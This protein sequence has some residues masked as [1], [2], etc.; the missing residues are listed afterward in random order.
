MGARLGMAMAAPAPF[1]VHVAEGTPS[2]L[3][4]DA[5]KCLR[6]VNCVLFSEKPPQMNPG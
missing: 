2:G 3:A 4:P 1:S 6:S 5:G